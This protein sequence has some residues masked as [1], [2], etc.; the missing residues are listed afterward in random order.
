[1]RNLTS[2]KQRA[3]NII[4]V[5]EEVLPGFRRIVE[6]V[7]GAACKIGVDGY[8]ALTTLCASRSRASGVCRYSAKIETVGVALRPAG[9]GAVSIILEL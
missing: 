3:G 4:S 8:R 5:L 6:D 9:V 1:M 2:Y 7:N